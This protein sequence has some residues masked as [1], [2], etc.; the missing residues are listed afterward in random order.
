MIKGFEGKS[1]FVLAL[2]TR[3]PY[4]SHPS[5][6]FPPSPAQVGD[7]TTSVVLIAGE[8][9][10]NCKPFVEDNVH[11]QVI[12]R[13]LRQAAQLALGKIKEIAVHVKHDDPE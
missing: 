9:L 7:G 13:G 12:L 11:P 4:V 8:I 6:I 2:T 10:R 1:T 5:F 3:V